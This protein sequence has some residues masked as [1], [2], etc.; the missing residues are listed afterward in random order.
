MLKNK[1]NI[2]PQWIL[3]TEKYVMDFHGP[4]LRP[5]FVSTKIQ[6]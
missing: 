3:C 4:T 5:A 2:E 6:T 1:F